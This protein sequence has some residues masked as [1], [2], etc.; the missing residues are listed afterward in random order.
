MAE[1]AKLNRWCPLRE[2]TEDYL[3]KIFEE[4]RALQIT[5]DGTRSAAVAASIDFSVLF[6]TSLVYTCR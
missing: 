6:S 5:S 3:K 4:V 1:V 2:D